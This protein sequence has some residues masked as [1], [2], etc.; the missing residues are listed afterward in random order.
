MQADTTL[1]SSLIGKE[2]IRGLQIVPGKPIHL[3]D[4]DPSWDVSVRGVEIKEHQFQARLPELLEQK[5]GLQGAQNKLYASDSHAVLVIFQ[6]M[7]GADIEAA[8]RHM[9][10]GINPQ[11]CQA[12]DFSKIKSVDLRHNFLWLYSQALPEHGRIGIFNHSYYD[13]VIYPKVN[14][15]ALARQKVQDGKIP[16]AFWKARYQD[17]NNFER[18]LVANNNAVLK[19]FLHSSK[20]EQRQRFLEQIYDPKQRWRFS[21][22][23]LEERQQWDHYLKAYEQALNA[24]STEIFSWYVSRR[25]NLAA[26]LL[27]ADILTE[28]ILGLVDYPQVSRKGALNCRLPGS[29]RRTRAESLHLAIPGATFATDTNR[30]VPPKK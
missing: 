5:R 15:D 26:S 6:G 22:S 16:G 1:E 27:A 19:F 8:I 13:E 21:P 11:G 7:A 23:D 4:I 17:I 29:S 3:T 24:T 18:H 9:M 14:P 12:F 28:T 10:T 2:I 30:V 25:A 20:E